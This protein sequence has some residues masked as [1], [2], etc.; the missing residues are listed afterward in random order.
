M[1]D[2]HDEKIDAMLRSRRVEPASPELAERIILKAQALPQKEA[3][4]LTRWMR[5][6]FAEFHLPQPAYVL[7]CTLVVGFLIG[8][9]APA[10]MPR[11]H[12]DLGVQSFLYADE[13]IL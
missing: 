1:S 9:M 4:S 10:D 6:I 13:D 12:P 5:R 11:E 8:V 2:R 3:M 7:S